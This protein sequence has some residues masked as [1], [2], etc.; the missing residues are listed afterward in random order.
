MILTEQTYKDKIK[1]LNKPY[2]NRSSEQRW[3][4]FNE[5]IK[6]LEMLQPK[7]A[8]EIG[9]HGV[10]L[11]SHSD[12]F[13]DDI[14]TIDPDNAQNKVIVRD[15]RIVPWQDIEDKTYDVVVA[16]QV[17]E[18]LSPNQ[19]EVFNEIKRVSKHCILSFPYL[20]NCPQDTA[21]HQITKDIIQEW[22]T[23]RSIYFEKIIDNRII[24]LYTF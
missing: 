6:L 15:C 9:T 23:S 20:W 5:V 12:T 1:R 3:L 8:L 14:K 18:H 4:Y 24:C 7:T 10:S 16:L 13:C 11:M 17:F 2:W 21:H 22:T 19:K